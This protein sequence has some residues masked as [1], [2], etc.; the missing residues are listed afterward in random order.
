MISTLDFLYL[1]LALCSITITVM[2]VLVGAEM[3]RVLRDVR[4][5]SHNVEEISTLLQRVARIVIPGLERITRK[6][7]HNV[8]DAEAIIGGILSRFRPTKRDK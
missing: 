1:I 8:E 2:L 7:D 3:L 6:A 5:I 4:S